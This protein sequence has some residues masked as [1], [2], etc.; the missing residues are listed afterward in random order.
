MFIYNLDVLNYC[1]NLIHNNKF[2]N[3]NNNYLYQIDKNFISYENNILKIQIF[4]TLNAYLQNSNN[5]VYECNYIIIDTKRNMSNG[6]REYDITFEQ[7]I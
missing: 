4:D 1:I 3:I 7:H 2:I 5:Q 6:S